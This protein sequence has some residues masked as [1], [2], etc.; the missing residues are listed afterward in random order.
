MRLVIVALAAA[1]AGTVAF[2]AKPSTLGPPPPPGTGLPEGQC[3]LT[4]EVGNHTVVDG[5][6]LLLDGYGRSKGVY[7]VT[8]G[9]GCLRSAISS[10]PITVRQT[11]GGRIC[12]PKDV[13]LFA[14]S[15]FCRIDSIVKL[16]PDEVAALPRKLKP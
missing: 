15:G 8:V 9:N 10:D 16:T 2:A 5:D 14:R 1:A 12:N 4:H 11:G 6:T 13:E 7:R 3:I